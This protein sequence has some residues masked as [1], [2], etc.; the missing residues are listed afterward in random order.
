LAYDAALGNAAVLR[1]LSALVAFLEYS[2]LRSLA[3]R[4]GLLETAGLG[5]LDSLL[6]T[7]RGRP[8]AASGQSWEPG[9]DDD[10]RGYGDEPRGSAALFTGCVMSALF[11][12][13]HR[14]TVRVLV[15]SGWCIEAPARQGCCG[16]LHLH[17]GF[18]DAAR[19]YARRTIAAF[20]DSPAERIAV[21]AAGC[22]AA[23]KEY[24]ALLEDD[25]LWSERARA[26]SDRVR[27][28]SELVDAGRMGPSEAAE[29]SS[30][31][32]KSGDYIRVVYQDAC[33]LAHAQGIKAQPRR[34]LD[35]LEGVE[36]CEMKHADRCCGSAGVY[37]LTHPGAADELADQKIDAARAAG[38]ERIL[39]ANPGCQIQLAAASR[40]RGGPAVQHVMD[41]LDDPFGNPQPS[42]DRRHAIA[43][44]LLLA[45]GALVSIGIVFL[46]VCRKR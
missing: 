2:G 29:R 7:P 46:A 16:A 13:T 23:M 24:G 1:A 18:K 20:E 8:F 40:R 34:L 31:G 32:P 10:P 36:R 14:S 19:A 42:V 39:T 28:A 15:R 5:R 26:F 25:E 41:F 27:D 22:G 11:G 21:N 12:D 3:R 45:A 44:G 37:N 33:H 9:R 30:A 6:P 35:A 43:G 4:T 38:A 17:A